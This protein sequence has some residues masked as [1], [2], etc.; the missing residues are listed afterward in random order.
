[1]VPT[2]IKLQQLSVILTDSEVQYKPRF[3]PDSEEKTIGALYDQL[4]S[5]LPTKEK[6]NGVLDVEFDITQVNQ[7][8][9]PEKS[10]E[11]LEDGQI[12]V[13]GYVP[14]MR[15]FEQFEEKGG[16]SLIIK[17]TLESL[18]LWKQKEQAESWALWLKELESF[19]KIPLFFQFF[20]KNSKCKDLL[21]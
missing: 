16:V 21:F 2:N 7:S 12:V 9:K 13:T 18:N 20:L 8:V 6:F 11:I 19:S 14:K 5:H 10:K 4:S 1:M 15:F 17:V 3:N